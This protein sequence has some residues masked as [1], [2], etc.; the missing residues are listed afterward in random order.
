VF[1][2][3]LDF[4]GAFDLCEAIG[5]HHDR[6]FERRVLVLDCEPAGDA[7]IVFCQLLLQRGSEFGELG[8]VYHKDIWATSSV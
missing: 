2:Y 7:S 6:F 5:R 4:N 3:Y 8:G 1:W